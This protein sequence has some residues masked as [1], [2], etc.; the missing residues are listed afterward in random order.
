MRLSLCASIPSMPL[1]DAPRVALR[2]DRSV[3][4]SKALSLAVDCQE[5][6]FALA[7]TLISGLI[8]R[9]PPARTFNTQPSTGSIGTS[10]SGGRIA[11]SVTLRP[12]NTTAPVYRQVTA[13]QLATPLVCTCFYTHQTAVT[14]HLVDPH[15][16]ALLDPRDP[17]RREVAPSTREPSNRGQPKTRSPTAGHERCRRARKTSHA[18]G[19]FVTVRLTRDSRL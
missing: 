2:T 3:R 18:A 4:R 5:S 16:P 15:P 12:P 17:P 19:R 10:G 6:C 11:P 13:R 9:S 7:W 1:C 8:T 14:D